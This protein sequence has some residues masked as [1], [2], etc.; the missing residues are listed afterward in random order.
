[1]NKEVNV[2]I[3]SGSSKAK[4]VW[5]MRDVKDSGG[6]CHERPCATKIERWEEVRRELCDV[7]FLESDFCFVGG[8]AE[9]ENVRRRGLG[10]RG[11]EAD[12][13]GVSALLGEREVCTSRCVHVFL[14]LVCVHVGVVQLR[15]FSG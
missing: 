10:W 7:C 13:M 3:S 5:N 1:M 15:F 12:F 14:L 11:A 8:S 4:T 6:T 9:S 2:R